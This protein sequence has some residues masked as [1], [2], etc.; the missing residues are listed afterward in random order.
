M[1]FPEPLSKVAVTATR[2]CQRAVWWW[3]LTTTLPQ[4]PRQLD[5][6]ARRSLFAN[7]RLIHLYQIDYTGNFLAENG[8]PQL[9]P[10]PDYTDPQSIRRSL[11]TDDNVPIERGVTLFAASPTWAGSGQVVS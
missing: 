3:S 9:Y 8:A 1:V 2:I 7:P 10:L 6:G 11:A 5:T 4:S